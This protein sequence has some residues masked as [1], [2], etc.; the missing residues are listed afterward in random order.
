[1]LFCNKFGISLEQKIS[2]YITPFCRPTW[3]YMLA[4]CHARK[5]ADAS[6]TWYFQMT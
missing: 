4:E 1:M 2:M 6:L 3:Y 5:Q